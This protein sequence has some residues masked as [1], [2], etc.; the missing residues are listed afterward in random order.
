MLRGNAGQDIFLASQ[1]GRVFLDLLGEGAARFGYRLHA[2]C[3][4]PNHIHLL[5]QVGAVPL[6]RAMQVLAQRYTVRI[7]AREKRPGHLFQGRYKAILVD[8][9]SYLLELAR[10][11]HL[12]P[13]RAGLAERPDAWRWSGHRAYLG[14][15]AAPWLTTDTVLARFAENGDAAREAYRRFVAEGMGKAPPPAL[16]EAAGAAGRVLGDDDFASNALRQAGEA[17]IAVGRRP[18]V[19]ALLAAVA[20]AYDVAPPM[21]A[22]PSRVRV[23]AEARGVAGL[24]ARQTGAAS[25]AELARRFGRNES[26]LTRAIQHVRHRQA[27]DADLARR[28]ARIGTVILQEKQA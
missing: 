20:A 28:I 11:I 17:E 22:G 13:V 8:A 10:Y 16:A 25:Q 15:E 24:L 21:L 9:D 14:I 5:L 2:Y 26:S 27:G 7:N 23:L 1:D 4:M 6:G 3:L 18:G 12:N 19:E